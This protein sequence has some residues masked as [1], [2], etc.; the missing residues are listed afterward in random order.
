MSKEKQDKQSSE[1]KSMVT[2]QLSIS[3]KLEAS[4][5]PLSN[6]LPVLQLTVPGI[7]P[8]SLPY[9]TINGEFPPE[10]VAKKESS[11]KE[12]AS[13]DQN[14]DI[15]LVETI[16]KEIDIPNPLGLVQQ[17][18]TN[19]IR[20]LLGGFPPSDREKEKDQGKA[21]SS[22]SLPAS[23]L[24]VD[25]PLKSSFCLLSST[26]PDLR[27]DGFFRLSILRASHT[28]KDSTQ[29]FISFL[30]R[31][32]TET[33]LNVFMI[34]ILSLKGIPLVRDLNYRTAFF[35]P[36]KL[37]LTIFG[38][39]YYSDPIPQESLGGMQNQ[40]ATNADQGVSMQYIQSDETAVN[41]C[42]AKAF[43]T[44]DEIAQLYTELATTPATIELFCKTK[45]KRETP[46]AQQSNSGKDTKATAA[47]KLPSNS[48]ED[49]EGTQ[50]DDFFS[51]SVIA[52]V[53]LV[54][55]TDDDRV[56][57]TV[58]NIKPVFRY[59]ITQVPDLSK[60]ALRHMECSSTINKAC[61]IP[62]T[63][64]LGSWNDASIRV[65]A[66]TASLL[67]RNP[68]NKTLEPG[69]VEP[70]SISMQH[71]ERAYF[72]LKPNDLYIA[73][74]V[75]SYVAQKNINAIRLFNPKL[76]EQ[77]EQPD[78]R[79]G[80]GVKSVG[81]E[82]TIA[83]ADSTSVEEIAA[84][85]ILS[86]EDTQEWLSQCASSL[87]VLAIK[88]VRE[89]I[90]STNTCDSVKAPFITGWHFSDPSFQLIC[91]E[92]P[93]CY[94]LIM[95]LAQ[96]VDSLTKLQVDMPTDSLI[97]PCTKCGPNVKFDSRLMPTSSLL[98]ERFCFVNE[99][100]A[101]G[102]KSS[103]WT[104]T[105][106][107]PQNRRALTTM[108]SLFTSSKIEEEPMYDL[109]GKVVK[110]C[111]RIEYT[112]VPMNMRQIAA[113]KAFLN[114]SDVQSLKTWIGGVLPQHMRTISLLSYKDGP[115]VPLANA[116]DDTM[117]QSGSWS[118]GTRSVSQK[119]R[120]HG[121]CDTISINMAIMGAD[122]D[123]IAN[124]GTTLAATAH[125]A[126][127]LLRQ[128]D[129]R[130]VKEH[131]RAA[132]STDVNLASSALLG[133]TR[134]I[135]YE[136]NGDDESG[137][138]GNVQPLNTNE[139]QIVSQIMN[140]TLLPERS[141]AV[142]SNAVAGRVK[143]SYSNQTLGI[144]NLQT[145]A[146]DLMIASG[147]GKGHKVPLWEGYHDPK[148]PHLS[149]Y[150]TRGSKEYEL[151]KGY[152]LTP[153]LKCKLFEH[154]GQSWR[155]D[156]K[157][158]I[159][160]YKKEDL[161]VPW[162]ED[163]VQR[164]LLAQP[165]AADMKPPEGKPVFYTY[166]KPIKYFDQDKERMGSV[167]RDNAEHREHLKK[168]EQQEWKEK[169]VVDHTHIN[170]PKVNRTDTQGRLRSSISHPLL[171]DEPRKYSL[172]IANGTGSLSK[173]P[174]TLTQEPWTDPAKGDY[175]ALLER[176]RPVDLKKASDIN[177][178]LVEEVAAIARSSRLLFKSRE[179]A[180]TMSEE[181]KK[182]RRAKL[183]QEATAQLMLR[184]RSLTQKEAEGIDINEL[185]KMG[186]QIISKNGEGQYDFNLTQFNRYSGLRA[187]DL[188]DRTPKAMAKPVNY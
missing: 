63:L 109:L 110:R 101:L 185:I 60:V 52:E 102:E 100:Q 114:E 59:K 90:G 23:I 61:P 57:D 65:Q 184:M 49:D 46:T 55:L 93:A 9:Y 187:I 66:A 126:S 125:E 35:E 94:G 123:E 34:R 175:A 24:L 134:R 149:R 108:L 116:P 174:T 6:A 20:L 154:S 79:M 113:L 17:F 130:A 156:V 151:E 164:M 148:L 143:F 118:V 25:L 58:V 180:D 139:E 107:T 84:S 169:V 2:L 170:L 68:V 19:P 120:P 67:K 163:T 167:I 165:V 158:T 157:T 176:S 44:T 129:A 152:M 77:F 31:T 14:A 182:R 131:R 181:E 155:S 178:S 161:A 30:P 150:S 73:S 72:Y 56:L 111:F 172:K 99:I 39:T 144:K 75:L 76:A 137:L 12:P 54:P 80:Q 45:S 122:L 121:L 128:K 70:Q 40:L 16:S 64:A 140:S 153:N 36:I 132:S 171:Q 1:I 183:R 50:E 62:Q 81:I 96:K 86:R 145:K 98:L 7:S 5:L 69:L 38:T 10:P 133:L 92:A 21:S 105:T 104:A 26:L 83:V 88:D 146:R 147:K 160:G 136:L 124:Y 168:K 29:K 117:A 142:V 74:I 78:T 135:K 177:P 112:P 71:F 28:F 87:K 89:K 141:R 27:L 42:V 97:S 186:K 33:T 43:V 103:S 41:L 15:R 8:V 13:V 95:P 53:N 37:S 91:L 47:K 127:D 173:I 85:P 119:I 138:R 4:S 162:D 3:F 11:K 22:L 188:I 51:F 166:S 82:K 115:V 159:D 179:E 18:L 48:K 106:A 32:I